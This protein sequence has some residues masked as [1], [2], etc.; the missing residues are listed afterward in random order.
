MSK[1]WASMKPLPA[2]TP[3]PLIVIPPFAAK[4]QP[5][6]VLPVPLI[7]IAGPLQSLSEPDADSNVGGPD[8]KWTSLAVLTTRQDA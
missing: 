5:S 2:E 8:W 6:N 3:P 1:V 4:I 7:W